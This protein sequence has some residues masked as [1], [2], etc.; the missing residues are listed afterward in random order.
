[1][2]V[3]YKTLRGIVMARLYV[4][5]KIEFQ[6]APSEMLGLF[7]CYGNRVSVRRIKNKEYK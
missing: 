7:V 6:K 1:M 5:L 3:A 4:I 2:V